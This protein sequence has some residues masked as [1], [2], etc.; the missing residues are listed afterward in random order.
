MLQSELL[1]FASDALDDA[2][3]LAQTKAL[4]SYNW[5]D[6]FNYLNYAWSDMYSR[7]A[8]V[9]DGFYSTTVRLN[10]RMTRLPSFVKSTL[11]VYAAKE[12][13]GFSR[14]VY[15]E[16]GP[17]D[18]MA[19]G[20]Y[21]ISGTDL[22]CPDA[23]RRTIWLS[24]VPQPPVL[25]FTRDNRNPKLYET[26][27]AVVESNDYNL[28]TLDRTGGNLI[29]RHKNPLDPTTL[30]LGVALARPDYEIVYISCDYPYIFVTYQNVYTEKY[31][32]GLY[33]NVFDRIEWNPYNAF[34]YTG[35]GTNVE[36]IQT[37]YNDRTGMGVIVRDHDDYDDKES[38]FLVKE[39]GW[40]PDSTLRYPCPEM[41]RYLVAKLAD[42]LSALN[43]SRP[44]AVDKELVEAKY[45]FEAFC[46]KDKS[47]W[48]R[49]TNVNAPTIG[50]LL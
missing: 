37:K 4:N 39:M 12:I 34:D 38:R 32:S 20:T 7:I 42:K 21:M 41:Y 25:F 2:M 18:L 31:E 44:M 45:G 16:S 9:D 46:A 19:T 47:A 3:R 28:Y 49:I 5:P 26:D 33:A 43:E 23:E 27:P 10:T 6:M 30:D 8:M 11:S 50:D 24:Y 14:L 1:P 15:R 29:L 36:Y 48:K 17:S 13:R 22:W 40:T 35:R